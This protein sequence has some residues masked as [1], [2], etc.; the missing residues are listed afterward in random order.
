M[1][2]TCYL[3]TT[4]SR[5]VS[6]LMV[7][8]LMVM[9]V[10][11]LYDDSHHHPVDDCPDGMNYVYDWMEGVGGVNG[12]CERG[13]KEALDAPR[14]HPHRSRSKIKMKQAGAELGQAQLK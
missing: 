10:A 9:V 4:M 11:N 3:L 13:K 2:A 1:G 5:L 6:F 14:I 12:R 7:L 8:S